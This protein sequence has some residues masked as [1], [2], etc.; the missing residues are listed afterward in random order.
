VFATYY[1]R[2]ALVGFFGWGAPGIGIGIGFGFGNVG[3]VPLA[4]FE[5]FTPWYGRGVYGG[6]R[7]GLA[8]ND[9]HVVNG[10][11]ASMYRNARVANGVTGMNA[12]NFGRASV[13]S[14][15]MARASSGDLARAGL[16]RGQLPVAPSR[17]STQFTNRAASTQGLP[18]TNEN[19]RFASRTQSASVEHVPFEQQRQSMT[20]MSQ[21]VAAQQ[22]AARSAGGF[23]EP[24]G[25][26]TGGAAGNGGWQ[27]FDPSRG[28]SANGGA[29]QGNIGGANRPAFSQ[30]SAGSNGEGSRNV[31]AEPESRGSSSPQAVRINPSIVQNRNSS[32]SSG[33]G[34]SSSGS[35]RGTSGARG[36]HGGGHR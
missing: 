5:R 28:G 25:R 31:G 36:G 2:P 32:T 17:E 23:G 22:S 8:V 6:F 34:T 27:R 24:G 29:G 4:P 16:V 18:R 11:V 10:N 19:A 7:G 26:S 15:T 33:R 3:W 12:A 1:W 13:N 21:R 20:Q 35:G 9:A 14:T 30:G